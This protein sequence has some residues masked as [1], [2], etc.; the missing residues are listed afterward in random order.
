[1]TPTACF[2]C[3]LYITAERILIL[4]IINLLVYNR[5]RKLP[6]ALYATSRLARVTAQCKFKVQFDILSVIK[7][8][9]A[10]YHRVLHIQ[11]TKEQCS[12]CSY[13]WKGAVHHQGSV[14]GMALYVMCNVLKKI[15]NVTPQTSGERV[16]CNKSLSASISLL[17]QYILKHPCERCKYITERCLTIPPEQETHRRG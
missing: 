1:M 11:C 9:A 8:H 4:R 17:H 10:I 5:T 7:A 14:I 16:A 6:P 2:K 13:G 12:C 3:T 15:Y